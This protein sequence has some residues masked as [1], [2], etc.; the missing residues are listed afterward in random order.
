MNDFKEKLLKIAV[1]VLLIAIFVVIVVIGGAGA[2]IAKT[3]VKENSDWKGGESPAKLIA[4]KMYGSE[5]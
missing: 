2:E 3:Y 4:R 5:D 1:N